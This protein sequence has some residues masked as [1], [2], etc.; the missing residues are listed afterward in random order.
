MNT[1]FE[2]KLATWIKLSQLQGSELWM[3][4]TL[5]GLSSFQHE[6][7]TELQ[8]KIKKHLPI[9][10]KQ[11][12]TPPPPSVTLYPFILRMMKKKG[13]EH[14][15]ETVSKVLYFCIVCWLFQIS[16]LISCRLHMD[17]LIKIATWKC[18]HQTE[19]YSKITVTNVTWWNLT[20]VIQKKSNKF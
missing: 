15:G 14:F 13:R 20:E 4:D 1:F 17:F 10:L 7:S 2:K 5:P 9:W 19:C 16:W 6:R 11:L 8:P 18:Y 3:Q 12:K